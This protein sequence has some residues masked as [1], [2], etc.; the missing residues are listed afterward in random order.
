MSVFIDSY[1][2]T[3]DNELTRLLKKCLDDDIIFCDDRLN[4]SLIGMHAIAEIKIDY[5]LY[6]YKLSKFQKIIGN[7]RW[8]IRPTFEEDG[9]MIF[10]ILLK[11]DL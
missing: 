8:G 3:N 5:T 4:V 11:T 9:Y 7:R 2:R 6:W 1:C 10:I